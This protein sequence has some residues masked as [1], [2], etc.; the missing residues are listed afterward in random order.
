MT[1][2]K[3]SDRLK[4]LCSDYYETYMEVPAMPVSTHTRMNSL[5]AGTRKPTLDELVAISEAYDVS[6]NYLLVGDE[7]FPSLRQLKKKDVDRILEEI[8]GLKPEIEY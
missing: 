7:M 6:I 5:L 4:A 2:G 1:D 8:E 3:F